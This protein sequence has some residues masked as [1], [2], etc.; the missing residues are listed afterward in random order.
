MWSVFFANSKLFMSMEIS[1]R[2]TK[3]QPRATIILLDVMHSYIVIYALS[4]S[5]IGHRLQRKY[6]E[7]YTE[8]KRPD[9]SEPNGLEMVRRNSSFRGLHVTCLT[10]ISTGREAL[11]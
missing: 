3:M 11:G 1:K 4:V 9:G 10:T 5:A 2:K 6:H 8:K 7:R